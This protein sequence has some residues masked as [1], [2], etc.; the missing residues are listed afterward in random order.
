MLEP[1]EDIAQVVARA[2]LTR[3]AR[4]GL[5][6][7]RVLEETAVARAAEDGVVFFCGGGRGGGE[8]VEGLAVEAAEGGGDEGEG[9]GLWV[10]LGFLGFGRGWGARGGGFGYDDGWG[11]GVR[12]GFLVFSGH[13]RG[14]LG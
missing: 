9:G 11:W 13:G 14:I 12:G 7:R 8:G 2:H 5:V 6:A 4:A 1:P 10:G 3:R